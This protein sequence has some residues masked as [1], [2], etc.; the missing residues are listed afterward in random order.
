[1]TSMK[2]HSKVVPERGFKS[3][4][5]KSQSPESH[6][7]TLNLNK[8]IEF[9][10]VSSQP[11]RPDPRVCHALPFFDIL[12]PLNHTLKYRKIQVIRKFWSEFFSITLIITIVQA[13]CSVSG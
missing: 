1:M 10:E 3:R 11:E 4:F 5:I 2:S 6:N 12:W 7:L 9:P 13:K 8:V